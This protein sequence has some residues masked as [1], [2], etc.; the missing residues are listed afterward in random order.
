LRF[1]W[2]LTAAGGALLFRSS[3]AC[4]LPVMGELSPWQGPVPDA[5]EFFG[6]SLKFLK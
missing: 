1:S 6:S 4:H 5:Q 3:A 2:R